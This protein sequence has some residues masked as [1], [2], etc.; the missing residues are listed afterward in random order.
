MQNRI[1]FGIE[2]KGDIY[3]QCVVCKKLLSAN[4]SKKRGRPHDC[5]F[6]PKTTED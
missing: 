2:Y 4:E 6:I 1:G 3:H 5:V